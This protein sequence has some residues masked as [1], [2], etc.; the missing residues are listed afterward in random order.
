VPNVMN[1]LLLASGSP[2]RKEL[3]EALHLDFEVLAPDIDESAFDHL[4]PPARVVALAEE[5]SRAAAALAGPGAPDL[6]LGA[7]TL[8]CV[9]DSGAASAVLGKPSGPGDARSMIGLLQGRSHR[10][11]TGVALFDR[12]LRRMRTVL[13]AS[14][15][16]FAPMDGGEI[17]DYLASGDWE[18]AAG[19]Y[20]IQG[21]AALYIEEIE[22]SWSGIVGL[23]I[24]ELY[25]ILRDADFRIPGQGPRA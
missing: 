22:G 9:E 1:K 11:Y 24:R 16:R 21:R 20:R 4:A 15:V 5:K 23:P 8:V 25:G 13:S 6:V 17:E 14:T 19:A 2:R 12:S 7:D 10:V 3:L 18:G